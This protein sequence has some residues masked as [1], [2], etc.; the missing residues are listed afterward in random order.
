VTGGRRNRER[1][2]PSLSRAEV[3]QRKAAANRRERKAAKLEL[4]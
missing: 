1:V 3:R 4:K 2:T